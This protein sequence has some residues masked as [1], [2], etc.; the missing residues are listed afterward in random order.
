[1]ETCVTLLIDFSKCAKNGDNL[2]LIMNCIFIIFLLSSVFTTSRYKQPSELMMYLL[3]ETCIILLT[4]FSKCAKN[5]D[6]LTLIMNCIFIF[7]FIII[8][9][10]NLTL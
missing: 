3:T 10:Y 8:S 4:D 1:M 2:T 7:F 6:N 9:V 5:G